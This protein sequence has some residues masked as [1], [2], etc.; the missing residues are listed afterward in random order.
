MK[1]MMTKIV[2][3]L[4]VF[5][6]GVAGTAFFLNSENTDDRSEMNASSLPEV[7]VELDGILAN[8][9]YGYKQKMQVDFNRDSLTPIDTSKELKVVIQTYGVTVNSMSY[10]IRTSDGSKVLENQKIKNLAESDG[11]LT[12]SFAIRSDMRM[13]QEYSLQITLDTKNGEAYYYTRVVQRTRLNTKEYLKFVKSF[14]EKSVDKGASEDLAA[15]LEPDA[16]YQ[17]GSYTDVNIHASWSQISWGD[18]NP[19]IYRKAIPAIKDINETTGSIVMEYQISAVDEEDQT[20]YYDVREFYRMRY[21]E[22]RTR[23]LDFN[24]SAQQIFNGEQAQVTEDGL[25][26]GVADRNI[27]YKANEEGHVVAFVQQGDLWSYSKE[28]NK[29]VRIFSFRQQE[30]G[31]FRDIRNAHKIKIMNVTKEGDVDFVLYGYNNRGIHEGEV[32]I[33]VYHYS[34]DQNIVEEQV[35]IPSTE[36]YEF[37]DKDLEILSYI[38]EN[39]Q[40]FIL[41]NGNLYQ[42]DIPANTYQV[43]QE[44]V[45]REWFVVSESNAHA[46]WIEGDDPCAATSITEI[47]FETLETRTLKASSGQYVRALGFMNEDLVYGI[48]REANVVEDAQGH[49]SFAMDTVK[50]QDFEGNVVKEYHK[51]GMYITKVTVGQTLMEI[52]LSAW[53]NNQYV[54]KASDNIMNNKKTGQD[55]VEVKKY[56]S[57]R[58][59]TG[60]M[61]SF[62]QSI[63]D[64]EPLVVYSKMRIPDEICKIP[65]DLFNSDT[66]LYYVYGMGC[67]DSIHSMPVEAILRA[68]EVNGVVLNRNQ[69]YIWERG[70]KKAKMTLNE[71]DVPE[72]YLA[73]TSDLE[74]LQESLGEDGKVLDLTGCTLDQVLYCISAGRPVIV[75]TGDDEFRLIIGYD[76]YN[77]WLYDPATK[78]TAPMGLG[79]STNLFTQAGNVF[80][81]YIETYEE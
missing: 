4:L 48:T 59:G 79:D 2:V 7:L 5:I 15:Y 38:N 64:K 19:K 37:L 34:S 67:L 81:T 75:K 50:I 65:V 77:T 40:L 54:A 70:N 36:S 56:S 74:K 47:D 22:D 66:E 57:A 68:D 45:P 17:S 55:I 30:N 78:A 1:R 62:A 49:K 10:E 46:A 3:L 29:M 33:S 6:V 20:E 63:K 35:F 8:R 76:E 27:S 21:M 53:E 24:R 60:V 16:D 44:N 23:L 52:E 39:H 73:C 43:L 13:N 71:Q 42:V 25:M 26:M 41:M 69:Q 58:Q 12:A 61:L 80:I 14:Y 31:D 51:D 72:S 9:M 18:L 28:A 32:G 11:Y